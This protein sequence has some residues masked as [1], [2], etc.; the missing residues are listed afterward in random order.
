LFQ[1]ISI[2]GFFAIVAMLVYFLDVRPALV[3]LTR[4]G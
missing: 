1:A 4:R 3:A 2:L